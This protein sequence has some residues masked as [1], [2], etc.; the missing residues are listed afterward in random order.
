MLDLVI[1]GES[2]VRGYRRCDFVVLSFCPPRRPMCAA[3][4]ALLS[5][6][7]QQSTA[8]NLRPLQRLDPLTQAVLF[9]GKHTVLYR[10][11][12]LSEQWE[13]DNVEGPFFLVQRSAAPFHSL[14]I[15]NRLSLDPWVLPLQAD[16]R[17]ELQEA[18]YLFIQSAAG[19]VGV[20]F[21]EQSDAEQAADSL[22]RLTQLVGDPRYRPHPVHGAAEETAVG[23]Q[24]PTSVPHRIADSAGR[25]LHSQPPPPPT[26]PLSDAKEGASEAQLRSQLHAFLGRFMQEDNEYAEAHREAIKQQ[27]SIVEPQPHEQ[28]G[29]ATTHARPTAAETSSQPPTSQKSSADSS[30]L[31]AAEVE[32]SLATTRVLSADNQQATTSLHPLVSQLFEQSLG[33]A[34]QQRQHVNQPADSL[35]SRL[36]PVSMPQV[37]GSAT[38]TSSSSALPA[39]GGDG[40]I[41]LPTH[42]TAFSSTLPP[43]TP[44]SELHVTLPMFP[45]ALSPSSFHRHL[46]RL[47]ADEHVAGDI[48]N[49]YCRQQ[50]HYQQ[51]GQIDSVQGSSQ[52]NN[53][54]PSHQTTLF[55]M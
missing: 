6:I 13:R 28:A 45:T 17:F 8:L 47:L 29:K 34:Q 39:Y 46:Q 36:H 37:N 26:L 22:T 51:R 27:R 48:Y 4:S 9:T 16:M 40:F 35:L 52:I 2:G 12:R 15:L 19:V 10:L 31:K 1:P 30:M 11:D 33:T 3:P 54:D 43:A 44:L 14:V 5:A 21:Y 24:P 18:H 49:Q 25:R 32:S 23:Q 55:F 7:R 20:W 42:T 50:P 38:P 53:N 41:H